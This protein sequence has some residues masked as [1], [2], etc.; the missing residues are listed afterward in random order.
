MSR[1]FPALTAASLIRAHELGRESL[2]PA[3]KCESTH[4][5]EN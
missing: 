4:L 3:C 2:K 1:H 5:K